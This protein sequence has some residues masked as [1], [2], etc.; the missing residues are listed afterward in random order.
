MEM[1][2][3]QV[4]VERCGCTITTMQYASMEIGTTTP[5]R[6]HHEEAQKRR[7]EADLKEAEDIKYMM[8]N[9]TELCCNGCGKKIG[10]M[11]E[12]DLNGSYFY[13]EECH[14]LGIKK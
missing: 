7:I 5:C 1:A 6:F 4:T 2:E 13:C 14:D 9:L 12:F 3:K 11:Y 8:E 10:F